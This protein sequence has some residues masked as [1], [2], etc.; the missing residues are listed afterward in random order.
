[1]RRAGKAVWKWLLKID[2]F[3]GKVSS[4]KKGL[5]LISLIVG[6][7]LMGLAA[8]YV[9][10]NTGFVYHGGV[11]AKTSERLSTISRV[12]LRILTPFVAHFVWLRGKDFIWL[13]IIMGAFFL[14]SVYG[15][16]RWRGASNLEGLGM[17]SLMAFTIPISLMLV[18]PGYPDT[19]SY[20]LLFLCIIFIRRPL[21][22]PVF[23]ALALLSHEKNLFVAP[24]LIMLANMRDFNLKNYVRSLLLVML[25]IVPMVIY[26]YWILVSVGETRFSS[27]FYL[28][29]GRMI[30]EFRQIRGYL[31]L[32][33]FGAFRLFWV[34]PL[35]AM[36]YLGRMKGRRREAVWIGLVIVCAA[37]QLLIA[38]DT[39][40]LLMLAF[41]AILFGA[42]KLREIW[43]K[44]LFLKG[45]WLLILLNFLLP[46]FM[47]Y[48][49]RYVPLP[50][51]PL[52][53]IYDQVFDYKLWQN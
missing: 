31:W 38:R 37:A 52:V 28:T 41:P 35:L 4:K 9:A 36:Y 29:V 12:Q 11:Y 45:L 46:N 6:I 47:I 15:Y 14:S 34:L 8:F 1:M 3:I 50:S 25:A 51:M 49:K 19:A 27:D 21:V 40:R 20:L 42:W 48:G 17:A 22:W 53:S 33:M 23:F 24:W 13:P 26:R 10:P 43:G 44:E 5:L 30:Y 32:G 16:F 7:L 18:W 39:T 2:E